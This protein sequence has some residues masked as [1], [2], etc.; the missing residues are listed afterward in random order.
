MDMD[1]LITWISVDGVAR[2]RAG[3]SNYILQ[4]NVGCIYLCVPSIPAYGTRVFIMYFVVCKDVPSLAYLT[5]NHFIA[6]IIPVLSYKQILGV[7]NYRK[8]MN[9][10]CFLFPNDW[11]NSITNAKLLRKMFMLHSIVF[12]DR[13]VNI[14]NLNIV[15]SLHIIA[16]V[17]GHQFPDIY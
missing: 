6:V 7:R 10:P 14:F 15:S 4:F 13:P 8:F 11:L 1:E 16:K 17:S 3:I 9:N 5:I 2:S 12:N